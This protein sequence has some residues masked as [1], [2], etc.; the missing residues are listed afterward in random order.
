MEDGMIQLSQALANETVPANTVKLWWL[1]GAGFAF[2]TPAGKV[3]LLD[4]YLSDAVE[5]LHGFKR[6][7]PSPLA[8]AEVRC[9]AVLCTHEHTD[10]LD[11]DSLPI[12]ARHNPACVFAGPA[13][14]VKGFRELGIKASRIMELQP[15]VPASLIGI[16]LHTVRSDHGDLSPDA[17]TP[18]LD[19]NG[20]RVLHSGD[21]SWLPGRFQPLIDMKPDL[22][23]PCI[24][25]NY[26][27]TNHIDAAL[28]TQQAKPQAVIPHH[29]WMFIEHGGDP[30]GFLHACR[31]FCPEAKVTIMRPGE[32]AAFSR[33]KG[34]TSL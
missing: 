8:A 13:S 24:N 6:M 26:G 18:L 19:F 1:G 10:H 20:V 12:I 16:K 2:K 27:N 30:A 21:T 32:G 23:L 28:M 7:C 14:S 25:G 9:D 17:L 34:L 11:P 3:L 15:G 29:F 33:E 4:P 5:R 31:Y 22:L